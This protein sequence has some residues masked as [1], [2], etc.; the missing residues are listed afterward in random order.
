MKFWRDRSS[1][2]IILDENPI[3]MENSKDTVAVLAIPIFKEIKKRST[4]DIRC[5]KNQHKHGR[6]DACNGKML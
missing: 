5:N 4:E 6:Y 2:I 3:K 1:E